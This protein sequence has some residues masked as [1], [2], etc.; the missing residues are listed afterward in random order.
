MIL[1][2]K[3][4]VA[5]ARLALGIP[6]KNASCLSFERNPQAYLQ[7]IEK[8]RFNNAVF[9]HLSVKRALERAQHKKCCYCE[10]HFIGHA[11]GDIEHFRPKDGAQQAMGQKV[12]VPGYYWLAYEWSNLFFSCP[13]CNRVA[14][15][16][17][18]PLSNP[19]RRARSHLDDIQRERPLI[20]NPAGP[21]DPRHHIRF[22]EEIP[23]GVSRRGKMTVKSVKLDREELSE[24]RRAQ[25]AYLKRLRDLVRVLRD[26]P[27]PDAQALLR[28]TRDVLTDAVRPQSLFSA[29]AQDYLAANQV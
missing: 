18:F 28:E 26:D 8:V 2:T 3:P 6:L 25:L 7:G 27:R 21:D 17:L 1:I 5:P 29:M 16:R 19:T 23:I 15:R 12:S 10:G 14:K 20:L 11:P 24:R 9:G 22:H 4:N 13:D